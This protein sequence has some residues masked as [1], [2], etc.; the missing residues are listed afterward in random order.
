MFRQQA[1]A[2]MTTLPHVLQKWE[3]NGPTPGR[4][5]QTLRAHEDSFRRALHFTPKINRNI[6]TKSPQNPPHGKQHRTGEVYLK[7]KKIQRQ[8][9][10]PFSGESSNRMERA[11]RAKVRPGYGGQRFTHCRE[12]FVTKV[13]E[14]RMSSCEAGHPAQM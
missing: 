11:L 10:D 8:Q 14:D 4:P 13:T 5:P 3:W 2:R 12:S 9:A 7:D 1:S 6:I